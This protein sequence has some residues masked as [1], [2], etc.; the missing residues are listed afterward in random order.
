[1]YKI[2]NNLNNIRLF[3]DILMND[4][5]KKLSIDLYIE[6]RINF[7]KKINRNLLDIFL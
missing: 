6:T 3:N 7:K 4:I 1:M 5:N 2:S